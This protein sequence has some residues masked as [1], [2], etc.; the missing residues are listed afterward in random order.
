MGDRGCSAREF[1]S[2][3]EDFMATTANGLNLP[4]LPSNNIWAGGAATI[5]NTTTNLPAAVQVGVNSL[6]SGTGASSSTYWSGAGTWTSPSG[7]GTVDSGTANQLAYY[8]SNGTTVSGLTTADNAVLTT[9]GSG[10]PSWTTPGSTLSSG[11]YVLP[12]GAII[13]AFQAQCGEP[14]GVTT[15]FPIAFPNACLSVVATHAEATYTPSSSL[16]ATATKT[17]VTLYGTITTG[18]NCNVIAFGY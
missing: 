8:A 1:N 6:N 18:T 15:N 4:T 3:V 12:G 2:S 10:A 5:P 17:Q 9:N 14:T 13:Q 16:D 7:S 11:Y